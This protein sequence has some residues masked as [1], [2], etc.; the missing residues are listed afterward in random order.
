MQKKPACLVSLPVPRAV[1]Q[2]PSASEME[3]HAQRSCKK[4]TKPNP[5]CFYRFLRILCLSRWTKLP[6]R[7]S[8]LRKEEGSVPRNQRWSRGHVKCPSSK[9]GNLLASQDHHLSVISVMVIKKQNTAQQAE[10]DETEDIFRAK[11]ALRENMLPQS[12]TPDAR[13]SVL[14]SEQ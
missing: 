13:P 7:K 12:Q 10:R 8:N 14:T 1:V 5:M 6:I 9:S 11:S 2:E 4:G 3:K